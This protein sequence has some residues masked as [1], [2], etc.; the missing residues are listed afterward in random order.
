MPGLPPDLGAGRKAM[1]EE[2]APGR[3]L[4]A[5]PAAPPASG[6]PL[7]HPVAG[8]GAGDRLILNLDA[9]VRLAPA[10]RVAIRRISRI[11]REIEPRAD[12]IREGDTPRVVH[13]VLAGWGCRYKTLPDG[14]R[15]VVSFLLPGDFCN[16]NMYLLTQMDHSVGAITRLAVA[17]IGRDQIE[18]LTAGS[19]RIAAALWWHELEQAAIQR[20]WTLNVGQRSA[21]ER[22]AHLFVELFLR[23]RAVGLVDGDACA[24]P[25][26]QCDVADAIGLSAVHVNRTIQEL[27]RTRLIVLRGRVLTIPDLAAL[28]RA[29]LF[30]ANY[31]HL[32]REGRTLDAGE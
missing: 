8:R 32:D 26:T 18:A 3:P 25:L 14:R 28:K 27:R 6:G 24:F 23:L 10:E 5:A 9:Y 31:L 2:V 19:P 20:E 1:A 13:L 15:Q 11:R 30:N 7:A 21:L 16:L 29:A 4:R 12:L 22:V 17:E